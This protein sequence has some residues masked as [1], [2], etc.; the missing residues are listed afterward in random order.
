MATALLEKA[1]ALLAQKKLDEAKAS[2]EQLINL[3]PLCTSF[4]YWIILVCV[5]T[6]VVCL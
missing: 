2:L 5:A 4:I 3:P 1:S 6:S